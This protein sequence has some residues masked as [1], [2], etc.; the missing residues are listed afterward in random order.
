MSALPPWE[1]MEHYAAGSGW[2]RVESNGDRRELKIDRLETKVD[3]NGAEIQY[4]KSIVVEIT[5]LTMRAIDGDRKPLRQWVWV[6]G[7]CL[8]TG[9]KG[10]G[11]VK[12]E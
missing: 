12:K 9:G 2:K 3:R 7:R 11:S 10:R 4:V 8:E 1:A 6:V 5:L